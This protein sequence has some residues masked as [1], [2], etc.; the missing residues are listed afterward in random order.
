[1]IR[2]KTEAAV[3]NRFASDPNMAEDFSADPEQAMK[4]ALR[5]SVSVT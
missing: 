3:L 5:E 1:M 4:K 2:L